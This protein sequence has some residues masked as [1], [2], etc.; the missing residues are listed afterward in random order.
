MR[1][2]GPGCFSVL[3]HFLGLLVYASRALCIFGSVYHFLE[4][5]FS[6]SR[7]FT[8]ELCA[9]IFILVVSLQY[10]WA[11]L[12]AHVQRCLLRNYQ[13]SRSA[14]G[15]HGLCEPAWPCAAKCQEPGDGISKMMPIFTRTVPPPPSLL[16]QD[17]MAHG[18]LY[19]CHPVTCHLRANHY[20][21]VAKTRPGF[22]LGCHSMPCHVLFEVRSEVFIHKQVS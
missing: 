19:K 20:Q 7:L 9:T 8:T 6:R 15:A 12:S 14:A 5:N 17:R 2:T 21:R 16:C 22:I 3:L 10:L 18:D 13:S 11:S 4:D 1:P